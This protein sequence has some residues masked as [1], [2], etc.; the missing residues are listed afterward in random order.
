MNA[1]SSFQIFC[2]LN[3]VLFLKKSIKLNSKKFLIN[4]SLQLKCYFVKIFTLLCDMLDFHGIT[5]TMD[6][7]LSRLWELVMDKEAWCAAVHGVT[8]SQTWLS[9][10]TEL[11]WSFLLQILPN[12]T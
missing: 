5:D 7:S 11:N 10:W 2:P 8:K 6:M 9:D 3:F 1:S 12:L 4:Y